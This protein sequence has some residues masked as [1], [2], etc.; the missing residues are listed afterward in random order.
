[1]SSA[2]LIISAAGLLATAGG[3]VAVQLWRLADRLARLEER[4]GCC[5]RLDREIGE[6]QKSHSDHQTALARGGLL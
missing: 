2:E 6:L 5:E 1:M 3:A 4:V